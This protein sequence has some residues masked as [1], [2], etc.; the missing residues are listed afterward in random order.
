M[1]KD[2]DKDT[3]TSFQQRRN[4]RMH[5][6]K[7]N[8]FNKHEHEHE[9][10]SVSGLPDNQ[11]RDIELIFLHAL[12][13]KGG[14]KSEEVDK[15]SLDFNLKVAYGH[16]A[17]IDKNTKM[18]NNANDIVF[19]Y[20]PTSEEL[21][22]SFRGLSTGVSEKFLETAELQKKTIIKEIRAVNPGLLTCGLSSKST[23]M[24][25]CK[26]NLTLN[27]QNFEQLAQDRSSQL[28]LPPSTG[29]DLIR[30][31]RAISL[32]NSRG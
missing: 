31:S 1:S 27:F 8:E 11:R 20:T 28:L 10:K 4:A 15:L 32:L 26:S 2:K 3:K 9:H 14:V 21:L 30:T 18:E 12:A 29:I 25:E 7:K 13:G 22:M 24:K 5:V 16:S 19:F 23:K 6:Q 17:M